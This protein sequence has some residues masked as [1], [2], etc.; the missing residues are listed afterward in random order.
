MP[1]LS[2]ARPTR[3]TRLLPTRPYGVI[4]VS[5]ALAP[6]L[7][8]C[9]SSK[10]A[11]DEPGG[12]TA[13]TVSMDGFVLLHTGNGLRL[14]D[15]ETG[16]E[17][18]AEYP[19]PYLP[20]PVDG[21]SVSPDGR[22]IAY[23]SSEASARGQNLIVAEVVLE[24]GLPALKTISVYKDDL[25]HRPR[26][27][28]DGLRI[29]TQNVAIDPETDQTWP[30]HED[31]STAGVTLDATVS[32][33]GGHRYVCPE[34]K[35]LKEDGAVLAPVV[36]GKVVTADGQFY[37]PGLHAPSGTARGIEG[38]AADSSFSN[39]A[40]TALPDASIGM[41]PS[42]PHG[43]VVVAEA[44]GFVTVYKIIEVTDPP[45]SG[46]LYDLKASFASGSWKSDGDWSVR[47]ALLPF[48][49][50]GEGRA[51]GAIGVSGDGQR[52]VYSVGSWVI[53]HD[54]HTNVI[55]QTA[56]ESALVFV[57][58]DG[59]SRGFKTSELGKYLVS[60]GRDVDLDGALL[61]Q[62][63]LL[64]DLG[65]VDFGDGDF[66]TPV[67]SESGTTGIAWGGYLNGKPHIVRDAG[68][69][70]LDGRWFFKAGPPISKQQQSVCLRAVEGNQNGC[71][72]HQHGGEPVAIVGYGLKP[73]HADD[74]P[75]ILM[76]SR[77]AAW[78]G[79]PVIVHGVHLG[80]SGVIR[81]GGVVVKDSDVVE[82][83]DTRI[84]FT[85]GEE[86]PDAGQIVVEN[87]AGKG[88]VRRAFWLHRSEY[89]Q[90][91]F[92]G[93][94]SET[95]SLGQGLNVV[96]LGDVE[97]GERVTI[98]D[99]LADFSAATLR[100]DGKLVVF[101]P[102]APT[103]TEQFATLK[104]GG[105]Q[106]SLHF[107]V[108]NRMAEGEGWQLVQPRSEIDSATQRPRFVRIAGDLV[109]HASAVHPT[110]EERV[111]FS[112]PEPRIP[113]TVAND[114]G[115]PDY[116]R[117]SADGKSAWIINNG[118]LNSRSLKRLT[119]WKAAGAEAWGQPQFGM[120]PVH[121]FGSAIRGVEAAGEQ[122]LVTGYDEAGAAFS[123]TPVGA[124]TPSPRTSVAAAL[125]R[126]NTVLREPI[127]VEAEGG[128]FFVVFESLQ[129]APGLTGVH[130]VSTAGAFTAN[131]AEVP[132]GVQL[133]G[134]GIVLNAPLTYVNEAGK[135]LV[136]FPLSN[137]LL[138]VD[139]DAAG[140]DPKPWT[141]VPS[142]A[143]AGHVLSIWHDT[144]EHVVYAVKDDG[145]VMQ[146]A[147]DE[148][149]AAAAWK[150]VD[151]E[152]EL[153]LPTKVRPL[154]L[155]RLDDGRWF[156]F[157]DLR[158][159]AASAAAKDASPF[160]ASGFLLGPSLR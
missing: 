152:I 110:F 115:L 153:A 65:G 86:L 105:F 44:A 75:E 100:D 5:L 149:G 102:G 95:L 77:L 146:A 51:Y 13:S 120:N 158:S 123:L 8:G 33:P 144:K 104:S 9:G 35:V 129:N 108:E 96:D 14:L 121:E 88:G 61:F 29:F 20:R 85:F 67:G 159:G 11:A 160:G 17:S 103:P 122:L 54:P 49:N 130:G 143:D 74:A 134:G 46:K 53:D 1:S 48:M 107:R 119:G 156:V 139:F 18:A 50:D 43:K 112:A 12:Q 83:T 94:T 151:L 47:E 81:V 37:S 41:F 27:S 93:L 89:V 36:E 79:S 145:E 59:T 150:S 137:T 84:V 136:H 15:P 132:T 31:V 25:F 109:E 126:P 3:I 133:A 91:P 78:P 82:W 62:P 140:T 154:A 26:W 2:L 124:A 90:T 71:V 131:V 22:R 117:E 24:D 52:V 97:L 55:Y 32:I 63:E 128:S 135:L 99:S 39:L 118:T 111:L 42:G 116:W 4:L 87:D 69:M 10:S 72:A 66:L 142:A 34:A 147:T 73:Q 58:R 57:G 92:D 148:F 76:T 101:S 30:C 60:G 56:S 40:R 21:F 19:T 7:S 98:P 157:A 106:H 68:R 70:S 114:F 23:L 113:G 28:P 45:G 155:S 80:T 127:R 64:T 141:T 6:V 138:A 16:K 125:A 38:V